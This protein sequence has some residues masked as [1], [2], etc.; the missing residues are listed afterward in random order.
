MDE[1]SNNP[2][3]TENHGESRKKL[4][5][6]EHLTGRKARLYLVLVGATIIFITNFSAG[7]WTNSLSLIA[8]SFHE[9]HDVF[10]I[11]IGLIVHQVRLSII[12]LLWIFLF[13][14]LPRLY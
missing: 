7:L 10:S 11:V 13:L 12:M 14:S 2:T 5:T 4:T 1:N 9:L 3:S 6:W 8:Q